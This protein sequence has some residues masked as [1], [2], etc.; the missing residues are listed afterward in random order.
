MRTGA[1]YHPADP[2]DDGASPIPEDAA[3]SPAGLP[4]SP[5]FHLHVTPMSASGVGRK[6]TCHYSACDEFVVIRL[7][8]QYLI[9]D[10]IS[11]HDVEISITQRLRRKQLLERRRRHWL[12]PSCSGMRAPGPSF[13]PAAVW[14]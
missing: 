8:C 10:T 5:W 6:P 9:S 11:L 3:H 12:G 1:S 14:N 2:H 4:H 7:S 13:N